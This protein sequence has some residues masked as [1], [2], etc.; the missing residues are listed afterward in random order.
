[1]RASSKNKKKLSQFIQ[2]KSAATDADKV[3][4]QICFALK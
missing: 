1:M 2:T 4:G 3:C